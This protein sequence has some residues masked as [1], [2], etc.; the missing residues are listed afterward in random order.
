M[1]DLTTIH[2]AENMETFPRVSYRKLAQQMRQ[3]V[4]MFRDAGEPLIAEAMLRRMACTFAETDP[5]FD[6]QRFLNAAGHR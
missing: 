4:A 1:H 3:T 5:N 6:K 2:A